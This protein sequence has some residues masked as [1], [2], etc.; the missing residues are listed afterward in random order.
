MSTIAY[1]FI[2]KE[3]KYWKLLAK[4]SDVKIKA[5]PIHP[6]PFAKAQQGYSIF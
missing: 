3:E 5:E 4:T 2:E 1:I 6:H